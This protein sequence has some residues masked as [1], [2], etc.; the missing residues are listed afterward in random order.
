[1][2]YFSINWTA[3]FPFRSINNKK[4]AK[5]EFEKMKTFVYSIIFVSV[6]FLIIREVNGGDFLCCGHKSKK[7]C[8]KTP[9]GQ[10]VDIFINLNPVKS[11]VGQID[12]YDAHMGY[13][14]NDNRKDK[15][16]RNYNCD[17][18]GNKNGLV[19]GSGE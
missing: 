6:Y 2:N 3:F 12:Y 16:W 10:E 18:W 19:C 14:N 17:T 5:K 4:A 9:N 13:P 15:M 11:W 1:M 8:C 7:C